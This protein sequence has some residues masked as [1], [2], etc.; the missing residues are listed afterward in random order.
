MQRIAYISLLASLF[1]SPTL[2]AQSE[3]VRV[4]IKSQISKVSLSG[5]NLHLVGREEK[6][7]K[8]SIPQDRKMEISRVNV[9]GKNYWQI[10]HGVNGDTQDT[11]SSQEAL[12]VQGE[13][14]RQDS[15]ELPNKI[16]LQESEAGQIDIIG[17]VPME[18]YVFSVLASE[19]PL[20]WPLETLKAQAVAIRSY[21]K[22]VLEERKGRSFHVESSVLDQVYKK[23]SANRNPAQLEKAKQAVQETEGVLLLNKKG[24]TLKAFYHSDCGGRTVS[25]G[26]VWNQE[27]DMDAGTTVDTN[28]P[29]NPM[30]E[31]NYRLPKEKFV[32]IVKNFL[33]DIRSNEFRQILGFMNL[34]STSFEVRDKE[35]EIEFVGR[36]FGHRVG[37][38]QWGSKA[39]GLKAFSHQR[40]LK[41][42]YPLATLKFSN[43]TN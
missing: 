21:T 29:M 16:L 40:I 7:N 4:R 30:A 15:T 14:L 43:E 1:L 5:L 32:N 2:W 11:V 8:V 28:C 38:C 41:H 35:G 31:W 36:G 22:A 34:R 39:L 17:V 27:K 23:I 42:Y 25:A 12:I 37:L 20:S 18:E 19:M 33:G 26:S 24:K 3:A 10:S 6:F 9:A 13:N